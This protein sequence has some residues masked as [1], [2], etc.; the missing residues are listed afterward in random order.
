MNSDTVIYSALDGEE[1]VSLGGGLP[2]T[3]SLCSH[4]HFGIQW[5][6]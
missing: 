2:L 6:D 4:V 1:L 5:C 3:L